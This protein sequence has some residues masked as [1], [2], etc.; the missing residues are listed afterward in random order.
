[1]LEG[2]ALSGYHSHLTIRS[3]YPFPGSFEMSQIALSAESEEI[4]DRPNFSFVC[5]VALLLSLLGCFSLRYLQAM[6]FAIMGGALGAI[7]LL[8]AKRQR[9]GY[10]AKFLGTVATVLGVTVA[11]TGYFNRQLGIEAD[12]TEAKKVASEYFEA[13][14]KDDM[15]RVF[16]LHG[17]DPVRDVQSEKPELKES[18]SGVANNPRLLEIKRRKDPPK[19][20]YVSLVDFYGTIDT[21]QTFRLHYRDVSQPKKPSCAIV[22]RK[23]TS[24]ANPD[25]KV[26][27]WMVE[28]L[29]DL[30]SK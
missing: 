13:I 23:T 7:C 21:A 28:R 12:V 10:G 30:T 20:E 15:D 14:R 16:I 4:V 22:V 8:T 19:W 29:D 9:L 17:L 6:P 26:A 2:I 11:S 3:R 1:M 18:V 27:T 24:K 25:K 5:I